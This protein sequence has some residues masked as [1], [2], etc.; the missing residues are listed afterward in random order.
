MN[1]LSERYPVVARIPAPAYLAILR[2]CMAH[3][4]EGG[5]TPDHI[6]DAAAG[7][8]I[9]VWSQPWNTWERRGASELRGTY[10]D[11]RE[12]GLH[13][14]IVFEATARAVAE[15]REPRGMDDFTSL[16]GSEEILPA[17]ICLVVW[18]PGYDAGSKWTPAQARAHFASLYQH[19]IGRRLPRDATDSV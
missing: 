11:E 6:Y 13:P 17:T 2:W 14:G 4:V 1:R 5:A 12:D 7:G 8:A 18:D 19:V 10:Y 15:G 9:N 16:S 3:D